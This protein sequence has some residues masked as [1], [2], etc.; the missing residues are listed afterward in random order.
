M[1]HNYSGNPGNITTKLSRTVTSAASGAGGLILI[2]TSGAHD[3]ATYDYVHVFGVTGTTE[4]N[5]TT[6]I[7]VIDSTHF[8]LDGTVFVNPYST[9]GTVEDL[10]LT[11][12]FQLPDDGE[13]GTAQSIETAIQALADRSQFT[14]VEMLGL[15]GSGLVHVDTF[16]ADG[17]W[18]RGP[19]VTM[20][21]LYGCG[22]GGGGGEGGSPASTN[23][24]RACGGA[25]GGGALA[26]LQLVT[27]L[28]ADSYPVTIGP[29][30]A[31][32]NSGNGSQ[33]FGGSPTTFG[34]LATFAGAQ[35]G[36]GNGAGASSGGA[37]N[38]VSFGGA[39]VA[40]T[41]QQLQDISLGAY[42][43]IQYQFIRD[44]LAG[45]GS[46]FSYS[47]GSVPYGGSSNPIG[48][49][50]GGGTGSNGSDNT[51]LGGGSGGG[52]GAGPFGNG[53]NAGSGGNGVASGS[54]TSGTD[55]AS[56]A[57]NSG[58]GGGGGGAGG[59]GGSLNNGTPGLG[60]AGGSGRLYVIWIGKA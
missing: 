16:L 33:G 28:N 21:L 5:T 55:G 49:F 2:G 39:S 50:G 52:G 43:A 37:A 18:T 54:T 9:G 24:Y 29:G 30:G 14:W 10:S 8:L 20:A 45:G 12:Y 13:A 42:A 4:A 59:S 40:G 15:L 3:F 6:S 46:S 32:Q 47:G 35:Q 60:G 26:T 48:G 23:N 41:G 53:A 57:A 1:P 56:A 31:V 44:Y 22:G 58:A 17:T 7:Q 51:G 34:S 36:G 27:G 38:A 25:G 11:P 19:G